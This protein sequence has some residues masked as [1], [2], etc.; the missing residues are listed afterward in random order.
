MKYVSS[1]L[2]F[3]LVFLREIVEFPGLIKQNI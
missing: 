1:L 2:V 3:V